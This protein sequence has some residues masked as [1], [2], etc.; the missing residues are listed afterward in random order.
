MKGQ[1]LFRSIRLGNIL[2]YGFWDEEFHLEPLNVLIGPN[3]SGKSNLI[4]VLTLLAAA[5]GG[6]LQSPIREGGGVTEWLWKGTTPLG[7]AMVDVIVEFPGNRPLRYRLTFKETGARFELVGEAI[8][9][10]R[11]I[12]K[13]EDPFSYYRNQGGRARLSVLSPD[14]SRSYQPLTQEELNQDQSILSQRRDPNT[15]PELTYLAETFQRMRFYR[16]WN[17]GRSSPPRL[18][19]QADMRQDILLEDA[20][21]IGLVLNSLLNQP[22]VKRQIIDRLRTFHQSIE[23]ILSVFHS[24]TVQIFFHEEGLHHPIPATRL[25]DGS[26]RYLCL[27]AVL[28]DPNPP[29]VVCIE[30][31]EIGL[32]PDVIPELA[33]LLVE[34]SSRCQIFV[35]THSDIL[36]DALTDTPEAV[37]VCEKS[38]G[39]TQLRRLDASE[40]EN[41]LKDYRLGELW[42]SGEIGGNRW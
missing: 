3:A 25:S 20:S 30:E 7:R 27:L 11:P 28:C 13:S 37:I 41:W 26:L 16:D 38:Q 36:I 40:L 9:N 23:D 24:N 15:Y 17:F 4:E 29:P 18:P 35:T 21:N 33:R 12:K 31:P 39:A 34:A 6:D 42:V 19:Q 10:E 14:E 2:S 32:H 22:P 1:R 5:P 8:G